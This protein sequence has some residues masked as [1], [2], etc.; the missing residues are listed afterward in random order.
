M[1][2]AEVKQ[3]LTLLESTPTINKRP[4]RSL[5]G[6]TFFAFLC[7]VCFFLVISLFEMASKPGAEVLSSV[8]KCKKAVM[9]L[10]RKYI[11]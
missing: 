4:F 2:P 3:G 6:A 11:C 1:F 8:S 5:F 10:M 7:L 9:C